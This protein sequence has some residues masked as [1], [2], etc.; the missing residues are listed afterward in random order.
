[1][2]QIVQEEGRPFSYRDFVCFELDGMTLRFGHG[3]IRNYF[4]RLRKQG[5]IELVYISTE[6]FY[7]LTGIKVGRPMTPYHTGAYSSSHSTLN[8]YQKRYLQFLLNIPMDKPGIHDIDLSF[9]VKGLWEVIQMYPGNLVRNVDLK[10]NK[11]IT[12]HELDF[13][14]YIVNTTIHKSDRVSTKIAC[15]YTPIPLDM[16]GL[17]T[18]TGSLTRVEERL[19]AVVD[20]Y[21]DSNLK[22]HILSASLLCK[23]PIPN[24]MTWTAKMWHFGQDSLTCYKG[25]MFDISW[26]D[27]LVI[28]HVYSKQFNDKKKIGIRKEIQEYPNKSWIE[29]FTKNIM[30]TRELGSTY[31]DMKFIESLGGLA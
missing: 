13:G 20:E 26:G 10:S 16:L 12:L 4:S 23:G 21:I 15:S 3:T 5:K 29:A 18:L 11:D 22:S 27:A 14:D 19:Q 9:R 8:H 31:L 2:R 7:T 1:M 6:A 28:F 25:D 30:L 24:C 17:A